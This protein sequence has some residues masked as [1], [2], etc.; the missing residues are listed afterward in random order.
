[1]V[2]PLLA[3]SQ[4]KQA[5]FTIDYS[6]YRAQGGDVYVEIYYTI[7]RAGL[8]YQKTT[9]GFQAGAL[10][11]TYLKQ[12][13]K[14]MRLDSL[15][16]SDVVNSLDDIAPTQKFVEQSNIL[17]GPGDYE[18]LCRFTDLVSKQS[19][20]K[21]EG[22]KI[23]S[24]PAESL[25]I[26]DI[27][28]ASSIL[29]LTS[30][31]LGQQEKS[32][33]DKNNLR[34]VPNASRM[35]GTGLEQ[36]SFYAEAYNL[37]FDGKAANSHYHA[38]YFI[39]DQDDQVIK[40]ITGRSR[41]KPG[42][43]CIINGKFDV[44]DIPSG[45]YRLKIRVTD[46]FTDRFIEAEKDFTIFRAKDF[47]ARPTNIESDKLLSSTEDEFGTMNEAALNDYFEKI[48][49]ISLKEEQTI[50]KKL[51]LAGKREFLKNFWKSR[52]PIPATPIN[53][54]K[55]EYFRLLE[56]A[57][58]NFSV[59]NKPGWKTD[60]GRVLLVY[61]QPDEVERFP[62]DSDTKAYQIWH[63]YS[64]EGGV[65]F[66]FVDIM[67]IRDFRLVHSTHRNEVQ[68]LEWKDRYLRY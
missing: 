19:V 42:T 37:K 20:I 26:S 27:Q 67:S 45:F 30:I 38:S 33:F 51:D 61:G 4:H 32:K 57:N 8:N 39:I 54:R 46:E 17:I 41:P 25:A 53:E 28:L 47:V 12:G 9:T 44:A 64:I 56:Y 3:F 35:Y 7:D 65:I 31:T 50:F 66:V 58:A 55:E 49:Y 6:R 36:L 29:P 21:S 10:I 48:K 59:G 40:E 1:M 16:I 24:F 13:N 18:L 63:Y 15:V 43:S 11:Q 34:V 5:N 2:M 22:L 60:Q 52:D 23:T 68:E 62:S 14:G